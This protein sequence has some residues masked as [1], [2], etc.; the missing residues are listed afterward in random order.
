MRNP[1][2]VL[3]AELAAQASAVAVPGDPTYADLVTPW[4]LSVPSTPLA[5]V[6]A[7]GASDV[8]RTL[9]LA[10]GHG[11]QVAVQCTGHGASADLS[12]AILVATGRMTECTIHADE[13]WARVGAGVTWQQVLEAGAPHGL[14]GLAGS[15][16]GAGVVGY[17]MGGGHGPLARTHGLAIDRVR[18][19]E[20][21][22]GDGHV[23]RVTP[24]EHRDL[25]WGLRG[26]KG[27]LGHRHR[28]R[29]R[30]AADRGALRRCA[31]LRRRGCRD[32]P[33]GVEP[34]VP[35]RAP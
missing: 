16:P 30:P 21:V 20:V 27:A 7:T 13:G 25:F 29:V 11:I 22:T 10:N 17:T 5:V 6:A 4:N 35:R 34:L 24:G 2:S 28:P 14:A 1:T 15:S 26:S 12:D 32:D 18:A 9:H 33:R 31:L 23:R 19:I 3:L 8:S